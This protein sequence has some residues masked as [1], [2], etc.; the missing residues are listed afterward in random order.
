MCE[1]EETL[2]KVIDHGDMINHVTQ[3][4]I[5][6]INYVTQLHNDM[7]NHVT[8]LHSDVITDQLCHS[9]VGLCDQS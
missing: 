5:D 6:M 4:H 8:Q 2:P 7:I 1:S 9:E 3:L